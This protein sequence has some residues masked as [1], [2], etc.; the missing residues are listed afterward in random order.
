MTATNGDG[1]AGGRKAS[2]VAE[3]IRSQIARGRLKPGNAL[4]PESIL[5]TNYG[6]SQ[7]TMR[8]ALRILESEG[9]VRIQ[10]GPGGG[11]RVQELDVDVLAKRAD[12]YLQV[13][14]A[15]LHD[16]FE[17]LILLQPGAVR[18][19]ATRRTKRQLQAL[20][21]CVR[22]TAACTT[23]VD[24]GEAAA[25]FVVLLL[26]AS[27]NKTIKLFSLMIDSLVRHEIHRQVD[28]IPDIDTI[29]WHAQRFGEVVDLIEAG[30]GDAAAALWHAH[31][32]ATIPGISSTSRASA[33]SRRALTSK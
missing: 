17:A 26:E 14:G 8:S 5:M 22:R 30:E 32:L 20:R 4:P 15:E 19:A 18:L 9:L 16:L 10:R 3:D 12:L 2:V 33:P 7:P 11:P 23:M 31:M 28:D 13:E 29:A 27:N 24:F 6:V 25:D 21:R 1:A